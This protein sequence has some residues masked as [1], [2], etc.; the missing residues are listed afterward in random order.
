M[1]KHQYIQLRLEFQE[2]PI[3]DEVSAV[4]AVVRPILAGI[5]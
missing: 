3:I 2:T 4:T 5:L 1:S